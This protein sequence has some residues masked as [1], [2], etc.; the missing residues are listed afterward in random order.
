MLNTGLPIAAALI[1]QVIFRIV[2]GVGIFSGYVVAIKLGIK[3]LQLI[4]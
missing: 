4:F 2:G 3:N 1:T